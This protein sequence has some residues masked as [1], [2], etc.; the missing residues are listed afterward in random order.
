MI[1]SDYTKN[2]GCGLNSCDKIGKLP[3]GRDLALDPKTTGMSTIIDLFKHYSSIFNFENA[4][5]YQNI[6]KQHPSHQ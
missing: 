2:L 4:N 5:A 1:R 6:W 3:E